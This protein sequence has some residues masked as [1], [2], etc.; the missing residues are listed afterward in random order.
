MLLGILPIKKYGTHKV[1]SAESRR[2][3]P[4]GGSALNIFDEFSMAA[5]GKLA[6]YIGF[7]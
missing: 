6:K 1:N 5:P 3:G 4:L 2:E 7:N